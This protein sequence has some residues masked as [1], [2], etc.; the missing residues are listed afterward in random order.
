MADPSDL[1][2]QYYNGDFSN[3]IV[4]V[5][6]DDDISSYEPDI[7]KVVI[8]LVICVLG[9]IGNL[10]AIFVILVLKE[11]QKSVTHWYVLQLAIAD[12]IFL[13]TLPF[14]VSED[15]NGQWIY[16][17]WMCKAK[18]TILFL[19]YY[20]S[21]LFLVIMSFDRYVAVCH[22]FSDNLQKMRKRLSAFIIAIF[23][24]S[25]SLLFCIPV[26]LFSF[27]VGSSPQCKCSYEFP[28]DESRTAQC[29][30]EGF[31][32]PDALTRCLA[33]YDVEF[34]N[35]EIYCVRHVF[36]S[37]NFLQV[38]NANSAS[39]DSSTDIQEIEI[40]DYALNYVASQQLG[41]QTRGNTESD[42]G[43]VHGACNYFDRPEGWKVFLYLNFVVMF[44]LPLT[45][46]IVCYGLIVRR[47]SA[48]RMRTT[49]VSSTVG[50]TQTNGNSTKSRRKSSSRSDKDR[51]R[52]TIMCAT[53]VS[54]FVICWLPFHAVHLAKIVGIRNTDSAVCEGLLAA[55][56]LLA[57]LNSALNPYL[58]SFLGTNFTRRWRLLKKSHG[59]RQF[60]S[61]A[62]WRGDSSGSNRQ[63]Q[64]RTGRNRNGSQQSR[65]PYSTTNYQ[66]PL[67]T[68]TTKV[69]GSKI[70]EN[71]AQPPMQ[72]ENHFEA[73]RHQP[74]PSLEEQDLRTEEEKQAAATLQQ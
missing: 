58:Y 2:N 65:Q 18:E 42:E 1:L 23:I 33:L 66:S 57:Y 53:L 43:L 11:Y 29:I 3:I 16:P 20:A 37:N 4:A 31:E 40:P 44:I 70:S 72:S 21:I 28:S 73:E 26:M 41:N 17:E 59:I 64:S 45:I 61:M 63:Y 35:D 7:A 36:S 14:K 24:W 62:V 27:K 68:L 10:V 8:A 15:L 12:S 32:T 56:S 39:V 5:E 74:P 13:L 22:T 49:S 48:T 51:R 30:Q 9:L 54:S 67:P 25:I 46:M 60:I 47:L 50:F 71:T 34:D 52:V 19:N 69:S 38:A 6:E 55:G